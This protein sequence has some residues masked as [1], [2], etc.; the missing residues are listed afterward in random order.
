MSIV[1]FLWLVM[2]AAVLP[3]LAIGNDVVSPAPARVTIDPNTAPWWELTVL[4]RIGESTAR[5]I[6]RY[7]E[8]VRGISP[9][10]AGVVAFGCAA[11]LARVR[12][13]G[14]KTLQRIG[15]YLDF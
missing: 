6:V 14:P 8:T 4:P 11:D 13:I 12:G 9:D 7:R 5:K 15:R 2:L 10:G 1:A 3:S